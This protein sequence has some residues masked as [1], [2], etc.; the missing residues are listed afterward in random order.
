M[1]VVGLSS[2]AKEISTSCP[3]QIVAENASTDI[4]CEY[5]PIDCIIRYEGTTY[6][7]YYQKCNGNTECSLQ[8]SWVPTTTCNQ[9]VYLARTNY[10]KMDYY[11]ISSK[12]QKD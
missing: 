6:R 3:I 2:L 11:C 8:V 12:S 9:T 10:M 7:A 5:N 4:C 1:A